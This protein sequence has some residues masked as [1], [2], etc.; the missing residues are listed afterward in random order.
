ML[1]VNFCSVLLYST[2]NSLTDSFQE[3]LL[4]KGIPNLKLWKL[5][6]CTFLNSSSDFYPVSHRC[7]TRSLNSSRNLFL[8]SSIFEITQTFSSESRPEIPLKILQQ[9]FSRS[10]ENYFKKTFKIHSE[11]P[12]EAPSRVHLIVFLGYHQEFFWNFAKSSLWNPFEKVF[13]GFH[14]FEQ[15]IICD[16]CRSFFF[17]RFISK[18]VRRFIQ[19]PPLD[20]LQKPLF[21]ILQNFL[22]GSRSRDFKAFQ[23]FFF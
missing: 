12:P 21:Q 17:L 14:N 23:K 19:V 4:G 15:K 18:C 16:S 11:I 5:T 7:F 13:R 8:V 2:K 10:Y 1:G 9:F 22:S 20:S 6:R 3:L